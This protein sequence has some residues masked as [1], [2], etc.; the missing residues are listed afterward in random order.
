[1]PTYVSLIDYTQQ[2]IE[3]IDRSPERL[4]DARALAESMGG[5]LRDFFLTMG[6]YDVV[7]ISEFPDDESYAQWVLAVASEGAVASETLK[8]FTEDEYRDVIAGLP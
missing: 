7:T 2:G 4:D 6:R 8:A 5:E 1:M 3:N